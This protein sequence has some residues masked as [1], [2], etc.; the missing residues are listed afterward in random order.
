[1]DYHVDYNCKLASESADICLGVSDDITKKLLKYNRNSFTI[2]HGY[3]EYT[4]ERKPLP[5]RPEKYKA[6]YVGNLL[7][8]YV[9]WIWLHALVKKNPDT[10]F[11]FAGS[12]DVGNLNPQLNK[13]T[14]QEVDRIA[15]NKNVTLLG[16]ISSSDIHGYLQDADILFFAY[17]SE[18]F[19]E[20]LSNSHKIMAYLG[21]GKP[22]ISHNIRAYEKT[23]SLIYMVRTLEEYLRMFDNVK[24]NLTQY[25]NDL[26]TQKRKAWALDNTYEKQIQRIESLIS[27]IIHE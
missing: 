16:E 27:K 9:N 13:N 22:I 21:S 23:E 20:I 6:L 19:P 15:K 12:Y 26:V 2:Q 1:M 18:E 4:S 11:Y 7:M 5:V 8:I 24:S 25:T 3:S 14:R 17:R 10:H